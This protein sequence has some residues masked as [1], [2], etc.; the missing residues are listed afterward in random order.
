MLIFQT[1]FSDLPGLLQ[2]FIGF[3][4]FLAGV[5]VTFIFFRS[6]LLEKQASGFKGLYEMEKEKAKAFE[7][8]AKDKATKLQQ[9]QGE[10]EA[11]K[12]EYSGLS[13]LFSKKSLLLE[14]LT[15]YTGKTVRFIDEG[16]FSIHEIKPLPVTN[17]QLLQETNSN[18]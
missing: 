6:G 4:V 5:G 18:E 12:L 10:H 7:T 11:L 9:L 1:H 3:C 2:A 15:G 13:Q 8:E 14:F 16:A 17:Q